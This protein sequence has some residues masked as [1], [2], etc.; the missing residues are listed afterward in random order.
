[1]EARPTV[2]PPRRADPIHPWSIPG[3]RLVVLRWFPGSP[4]DPEVSGGNSAA[5]DRRRHCGDW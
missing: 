3:L 5:A 2:R 1:V 4:A